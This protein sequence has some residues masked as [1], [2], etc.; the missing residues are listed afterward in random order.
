MSK[1]GRRGESAD[2]A[3]TAKQAQAAL[4]ACHDLIDRLIIKLGVYLGLRVGEMVHMNED[5]ITQQGAFRIPRVQKCNCASCLRNPKHPGEWWSKTPASAATL[6]IPEPVKKDLT[7]LLR[8]QPYGLGISR[9]AIWMR[10]KDIL[11]RANIKFKGTA[12]DTG[13]THCL[14]AT[15]ASLLA[16]GGMNAL[17]IATFLRWEDSNMA[18]VYVQ[19]MQVKPL[20]FK[21]VK[22]ILG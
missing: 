4:K 13:F 14:R 15:C 20:A 16:A 8:V 17:E 5:W 1:R 19:M 2:Y 6:P 3:L 10:T 22:E 21:K 11:T 12:R 18:K 7:E 9:Q